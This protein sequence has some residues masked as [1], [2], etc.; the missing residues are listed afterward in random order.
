MMITNTSLSINVVKNIRSEKEQYHIYL[1]CQ[2]KGQLMC[3]A[4]IFGK[5]HDYIITFP[6][7]DQ[8][9]LA[10]IMIIAIEWQLES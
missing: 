2:W 6:Y 9:V 7:K 1:T 3:D 10:W 4:Q 8:R 5:D